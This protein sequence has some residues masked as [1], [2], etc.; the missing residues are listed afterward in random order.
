MVNFKEHYPSQSNKKKQKVVCK[1][2][3]EVCLLLILYPKS[4][5]I[6]HL[7]QHFKDGSYGIFVLAFQD[8]SETSYDVWF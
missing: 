3:S 8:G 2:F 1:R 5:K 6:K 4:K 7:S